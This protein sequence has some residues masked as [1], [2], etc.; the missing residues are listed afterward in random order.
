MHYKS[1]SRTQTVKVA[2]IKCRPANH[3]RGG[4][5][6][7]PYSS[8]A[9]V[10]RGAYK[11]HQGDDEIV[12]EPMTAVLWAADQEY[13]VS[14]PFGCDD[15]VEFRFDEDALRE[16]R[17]SLRSAGADRIRIVPIASAVNWRL[18][19]A[20]ERLEAGAA[21]ALEAEE[22]GLSLLGEVGLVEQAVDRREACGDGRG[23]RARARRTVERAKELLISDLARN[24]LLEEIA[25]EV[26]ASPYHLTRLFGR[27]AG[28]SLHQ[29]LT[30]QR[31]A[32]ALSQILQGADDLTALALDFGFSS[33]SH[34]SAA[35]KNGYGRSPSTARTLRA[36]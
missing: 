9:F 20:V 6:A 14:H 33:H 2:A 32:A 36:N 12:V 21:S 7:Q 11:F 3:G 8:L 18:N 28:T 24:W 22:I 35:F 23:N 25:R 4:P 29:Y 15:C 31:L 1:L 26:G 16:A 10:R 34:F 5:E 13:S 30:R 19:V 27:Y 17:P